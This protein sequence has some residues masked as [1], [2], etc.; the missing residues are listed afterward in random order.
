MKSLILKDLYGI[1][2]QLK[3]SLLLFA[4]PYL[5]EFFAGIGMT[6]SEDPMAADGV[7]ILYGL[8][9]Y[10]T[11]TIFSSL[12]LNTVSE[13]LRS[14]WARF[15]RTLPL[16]SG[17]IVGGKIFASLALI[18][19][20]A[21][22]SIAS[23][24]V[25]VLLGNANA[26]PLIMIPLVLGFLQAAAL[27]PVFPIAMRFG[28]KTANL[29]YLIFMILAAIV[30]VVLAFMIGANDLPL[31]LTRLILYGGAPLL[32]AAVTAVSFCAARRALE[33]SEG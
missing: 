7:V 31:A 8:M 22:L 20:L 9:N 28:I 6:V 21:A 25:P 14:G 10:I 3:V 12:F 26:E 4:L 2:F 27:T 13:D 11:I 23:N 30:M 15:Q 29:L 16:T 1:S 18:G 19:V 33:N 32:A 17:Q 24:M 5:M